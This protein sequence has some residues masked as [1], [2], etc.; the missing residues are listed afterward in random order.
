[1]RTDRQGAEPRNRNACQVTRKADPTN[2]SD[3]LD[4]DDWTGG[5]VLALTATSNLHVAGGI[6]ALT[7]GAGG[8]S[9]GTAAAAQERPSRPRGK[10]SRP[11]M[12]KQS[13]CE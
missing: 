4:T 6:L 11:S 7:L 2:A 1:M 13:S 9:A 3:L 10:R 5:V 12:D 8:I